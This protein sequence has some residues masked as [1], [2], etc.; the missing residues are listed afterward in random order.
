M[1]SGIDRNLK[2]KMDHY[3]NWMTILRAEIQ[4]KNDLGIILDIPTK[5]ELKIK[6]LVNIWY[7]SSVLQNGIVD[8][9]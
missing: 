9:G 6:S 3:V 2:Y 8:R 1:V 4:R 5:F 7:V